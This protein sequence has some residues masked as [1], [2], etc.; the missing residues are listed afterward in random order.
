MVALL[1]RLVLLLLVCPVVA[2]IGFVAAG[3]YD[4][5]RPG[6]LAEARNLVVPKGSGLRQIGRLLE[7]N[8]IIRH[9]GTFLA[10]MRVGEAGEHIRAGEYAF[11]PEMSVENVIA[12]L[13]S[14]EMVVRRLTIPEGLTTAEA[15]RRLAEA[16][17]LVGDPPAVPEG[18]L[19]PDTYLYSWGDNRAEIVDRMR[20]AMDATLDRLWQQRS[21]SLVLKSPDEVLTLASIVEKETGTAAER[22]RIAAVFLNRLERGMKLQSDPTVIYAITGGRHLQERPLTRK[23]LEMASPYNTYHA[24]GLPPGP[25]ANPG[26]ASLQAVVKPGETDEFYFVADGTGGHAFARTLDEH[27]RNVQKW[28]RIQ[29]DRENTAREKPDQGAQKD[30]AASAARAVKPE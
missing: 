15:L 25:I 27:N 12:K 24:D 17:G 9:G 20:K 22:P 16:E 19:L 28:R 2:A 18:R 10:A 23:D 4:Y 5:T 6:P 21:P 1:R 26:L 14:G 13:L 8:G 11:V 29:R 7:E 3:W 30:G